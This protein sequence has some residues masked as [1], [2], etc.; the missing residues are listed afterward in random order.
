MFPGFL[1][2]HV[3]LS[4]FEIRAMIEATIDGML[5]GLRE[6]VMLASHSDEGLR[7]DSEV[8]KTIG[9]Y[10][11]L[12]E[13]EM[14]LSPVERDPIF[15]SFSDFSRGKRVS[16]EKILLIVKKCGKVAASRRAFDGDIT[17]RAHHPDQHALI[18]TDER[19]R[20]CPASATW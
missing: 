5:R 1:D 11:G 17:N 6:R 9:D 4:E 15:L 3:I 18:D 19:S 12:L 7:R 14:G 16:P 13:Y 10:R 8:L 20:A 2:R